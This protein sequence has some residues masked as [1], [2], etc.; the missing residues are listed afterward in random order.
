[1]KR[2]GPRR[3]RANKEA[4]QLHPLAG[5]GA[6]QSL[7]AFKGQRALVEALAKP[8]SIPESC[9]MKQKNAV[10]CFMERSLS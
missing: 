9:C 6:S 7:P 1:M 4:Q 5:E 10:S 8:M 3:S 2:T